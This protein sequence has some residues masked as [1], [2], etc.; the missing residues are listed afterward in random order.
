ME[1]APIT[2]EDIA[3]FVAAIEGAFHDVPSPTDVER[4]TKKLEPERTLA[5]RDRGKIV[6]GA[7][8][9]TRRVSVPGGDVPVAAV[10]QVGVL[11]THR[12]RG[13]L[14]AL[15]RRQLDDVRE[16]GN[17]A[18]AML[19]AAEGVIYGRYG[20]GLASLAAELEVDTTELHLRAPSDGRPDLL[21]P[22]AAVE[23]MRPIHAAV[24]R[25]RPGMVDREGPW[26]EV[27]IA[28][29]ESDRDGAS[30]LRAA[31]IEDVAYAL[32]AVKMKYA[33]N[34]MAGE[35]IV[36]EAMAATPEGYAAIWQFLLNL[37]LTRRLSYR[38]APSD[39]PLMHL[40]TEAQ[41]APLQLSESLWVRLVDLPRALEERTYAQP[42]EVV[43]EVADDFCPWNAG[44][45]ALRWDGETAACARTSLH[46]GLELSAVELG[47]AYLGGT[48]LADLARAGRVRELREG[49]LTAASRAFRA[50]VAPWCPEIF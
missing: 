44:R 16:A 17:E 1:P 2:T 35:V 9:Y 47:A 5:I 21:D 6:A 8:I 29:P 4:I 43:F 14:T 28:D 24:R 25:L 40:V 45:W 46:A 38:L 18:I 31:V 22:P 15:M 42:F 41:G 49:A 13:M 10:T 50:D 30:P 20:Y 19:W 26:W 11:P 3:D 48:T 33:H 37:D 36:R 34:R 27:R 7:S 12:R 23:A 39:E 32:Y